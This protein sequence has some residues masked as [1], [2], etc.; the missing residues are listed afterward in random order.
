MNYSKSAHKRKDNS[1]KVLALSHAFVEAE[2]E[3]D[4]EKLRKM[5]ML[6]MRIHFPFDK[7]GS[8]SS[9]SMTGIPSRIGYRRPHAWQIIRSPASSSRT[10]PLQAG[11]ARISKNSLS[12]IS[13][14]SH[15]EVDTPS[16]LHL[17]SG[18]FYRPH[19]LLSGDDHDIIQNPERVFV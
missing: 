4:E 7:G 10:S 1:I 9:I 2:V 13:P 11:H 18:L 14:P 17:T 15:D 5:Q 19:D 6:S 12:I 16:S 3:T 8:A